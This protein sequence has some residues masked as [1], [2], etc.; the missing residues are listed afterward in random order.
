M[1]R[2]QLAHAA[3][4]EQLHQQMEQMHKQRS[5]DQE[6]YVQ[7]LQAQNSRQEEDLRQQRLALQ[8]EKQHAHDIIK[9]LI[10]SQVHAVSCSLSCSGEHA[11][12]HM[13]M[14]IAAQL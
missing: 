1:L 13:H 12:H 8:A 9:K 4:K 5:E 14:A 2:L 7:L 3:E 6:R 11:L 10:T